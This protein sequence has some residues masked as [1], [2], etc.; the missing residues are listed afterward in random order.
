MSGARKK[1][2]KSPFLRLLERADRLKTV[3]AI[4]DAARHGR[5]DDHIMELTELL[6][7]MSTEE[8][9]KLRAL[10]EADLISIGVA[11]GADP[12]K[13]PLRPGQLLDVEDSALVCLLDMNTSQA[14]VWEDVAL[15]HKHRTYRQV[16]GQVSMHRVPDTIFLDV[17][18]A[19]RAA[20]EAEK[21]ATH[22]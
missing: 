6:P 13:A 7:T 8:M 5:D 14:R 10:P 21:A 11:C 2:K 9:R 22:A 3:E 1:Q 12:P 18:A 16:C 4:L 17:M 20:H 19:L 15:A